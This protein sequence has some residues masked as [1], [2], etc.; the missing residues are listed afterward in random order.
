MTDPLLTELDTEAQTTRRVLE[1]IPEGKLSWKPHPKSYSLGQLGLHTA[2]IPG[3]LAGLLTPDSITPPAFTQ[4]EATS[5]AEMFNALD[6][7]V[8]TAR[9]MISGL[10]PERANFIWTMSVGG[11]DVIAAP[12]IAL[13]RALMFNHWYHHRGQLLV[14]LRMLDVPLPSVYGPTADENPFM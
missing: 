6:G 3:A 7:S 4:P 10:T 12:R 2:S 14:Y 13:V 9:T 5:Q 11:K 8:A 1:R